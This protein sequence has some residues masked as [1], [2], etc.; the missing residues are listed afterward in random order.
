M[1]ELPFCQATFYGIHVIGPGRIPGDVVAFL[2]HLVNEIHNG[3]GKD[4]DSSFLP[5]S[6]V[7][8]F[9]SRGLIDLE[10]GL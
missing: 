1:A 10:L 8:S 3:I 5:I 2:K 7:T 9:R 4:E 6:N